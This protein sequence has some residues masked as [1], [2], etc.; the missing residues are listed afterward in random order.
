MGRLEPHVGAMAKNFDI[1]V[2]GKGACWLIRL[3]GDV[4]LSTAPR[5]RAALRDVFR[6]GGVQAVIVDLQG[7]G[8]VDSSGIAG[9]LEGFHEANAKEAKFILSG[10]SEFVSR[11]LSVTR[12]STLLEVAGSPEEALE[13]LG[14]DPIEFERFRSGGLA[15]S[16]EWPRHSLQTI[17]TYLPFRLGRSVDNSWILWPG[18]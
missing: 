2:T 3:S 5:L 16:R 9:L 4:N 7:V 10:P 14:L 12:L 1:D 6:G 17:E 15:G 18:F 8:R 13:R 11:V